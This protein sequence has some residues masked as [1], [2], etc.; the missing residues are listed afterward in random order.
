MWGNSNKLK[1]ESSHALNILGHYWNQW[2]IDLTILKSEEEYS[3][4]ML[5][6]P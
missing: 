6:L 4:H 5:W 1:N 2:V 3:V